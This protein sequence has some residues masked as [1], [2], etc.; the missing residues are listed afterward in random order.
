MN[1]IELVTSSESVAASVYSQLPES[2]DSASECH[3]IVLEMTPSEAYLVVTEGIKRLQSNSEITSKEVHESQIWCSEY[4]SLKSIES[5]MECFGKISGEI[6]VNQFGDDVLILDYY[7][8]DRTYVHDGIIGLRGPRYF[9]SVDSNLS[10]A[11][12]INAIY[13]ELFDAINVIGNIDRSK[14]GLYDLLPYIGILDNAKQQAL[15][16]FH[17]YT[18]NER[19]FG[20]PDDSNY[21]QER[22]KLFEVAVSTVRCFYEACLGRSFSTEVSFDDLYRVQDIFE[23]KLGHINP[24]GFKI[25]ELDHP[26]RILQ[27]AYN[28]SRS[29]PIDT[30]VGFPSGSTQLA[31]ATALMSEITQDTDPKIVGIVLVPLSQHSGVIKDGRTPIS[32]PD[33]FRSIEKYDSQLR[34]KRVLIAD[35]NASTGSTIRRAIDAISRTLPES[36]RV[37]IAEIDPQRILLRALNVNNPNGTISAVDLRHPTF[38]NSV[39]I[40]PITHEDT[41]LRKK[42]AE[43]VLKS[44]L[45]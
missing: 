31:I 6:N 19:R 28:N 37:G 29:T 34:N 4:F 22:E 45:A 18:Y 15:S 21:S 16:L 20:I 24:R 5:Y 35:D 44:R 9:V 3:D 39:G 14:L 2:P 32:D 23:T 40:V 25:Q 12:R 17:I 26:L 38:A 43:E 1:G 33:L 10:P 8:R 7:N 41:Q 13:N 30:I 42:Y 11:Q 36:L 27:S